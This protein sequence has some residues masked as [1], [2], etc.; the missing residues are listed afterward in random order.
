MCGIVGI[1]GHNA[2]VA[3]EVLERATKSLAHRGPDDSGT[4]ILRDAT[5][6]EVEIGLGS[7]RLAILDLSP[8]GHQPMSDLETGNWIVYNGEVYN[9]RDVRAKLE[10]EGVQFRSH[11]DTEVILK[12]Y[13]RWGE[14]M[15]PRISWHVCLRHL[16]CPASSPVPR[17]RP[18]GNQAALFLSV[19]AILP[20]FF[21]SPYPARN[22]PRAAPHRFRGP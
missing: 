18:H 1:I 2:H 13:G 10:R 14:P 4:L 11:S 20:V 6:G 7:R 9:F 3:P 19:G 16:G 15:P 22:R 12:S 17:P 21:R 8:L 5:Q